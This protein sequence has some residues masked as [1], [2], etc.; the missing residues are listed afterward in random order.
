M[1]HFKPGLTMATL[2]S[3]AFGLPVQAAD[4]GD[5]VEQRLDHR[6]DRI[7]QRLDRRGDRIEHRLD[8]RGDVIDHRLDRK[9]ARF[10]RRWDRHHAPRMQRARPLPPRYRHAARR[11]PYLVHHMPARPRR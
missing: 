9:G 7:E 6:G 2:V 5:R 1:K 10:D 4:F 3:L 8:R 11:A